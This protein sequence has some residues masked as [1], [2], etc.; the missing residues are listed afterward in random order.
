MKDKE[1]SMPLFLLHCLDKPDSLPLRLSTRPA[2]LQ[3]L[4]ANK[5]SIAMGGPFFAPDGESMMGSML[6]LKA[7]NLAAA[8]AL[9]KTDPYSQAGL[10]GQVDVR[11]FRWFLN[12]PQGLD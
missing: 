5:D 10:F 11:P 4:E 8:Q 1:N 12:K 9:A 7:E 6:V 2:H 3:W